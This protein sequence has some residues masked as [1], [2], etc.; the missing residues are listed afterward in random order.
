MKTCAA[1]ILHFNILS[2]HNI[3]YSVVQNQIKQNNL[4]LLYF[5]KKI[6]TVMTRG[7]NM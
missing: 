1:Y 2:E 3:L 7:K 4:K 6:I 5:E